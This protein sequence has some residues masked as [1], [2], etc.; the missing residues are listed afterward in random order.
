MRPN[1]GSFG[2]SECLEMTRT[3]GCVRSS[4]PKRLVIPTHAERVHRPIV[5]TS[6]DQ[7]NPMGSALAHG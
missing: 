1:P 2:C 7:L 4:R 3:Q 6:G 5:Q